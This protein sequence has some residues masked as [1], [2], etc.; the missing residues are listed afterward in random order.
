MLIEATCSHCTETFLKEQGAVNRAEK[1]GLNIYCSPGCSALG[2][3]KWKTTEQKKKEK[4]AYDAEY[5]EKN[6]EK[7]KAEKRDYF[8]KTYDPEEARVKRKKTMPRH[9]EYCRRPEY[10]EKKKEYDKGYRA[11][12][13]Y[14]EFAEAVVVLRELE[15]EIL[16]RASKYECMLVNGT[17]NK[18][19]RR[20]RMYDGTNSN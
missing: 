1:A 6:R 15:S 5:R 20:R 8:K 18:K 4:A 2:R 7:L 3:R 13:E 19:L 17:I 11:K 14:G 10:K 9:V 16:A 12:K